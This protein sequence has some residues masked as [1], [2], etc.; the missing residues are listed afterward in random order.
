[1]DDA[2]LVGE[3]ERARDL[4]RDVQGVALR[5]ARTAR[6]CSS[7]REPVGERVTVDELEN[8]EPDL[9]RLLEAV[10]RA[11]VRMIQRGQRARFA[12]E[13]REPAGIAG[14]GRAAGP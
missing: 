9:V 4:S 3:V 1:M 12:I 7:C 8:E 10:N 5:K 2:A 14:E 13:A 6:R 11:D